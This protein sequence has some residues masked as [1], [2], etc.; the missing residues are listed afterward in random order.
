MP[1]VYQ[2]SMIVT[3][4]D[5]APLRET[6]TGDRKQAVAWLRA[7]AEELDTHDTAVITTPEPPEQAA[8]RQRADDEHSRPAS[9]QQSDITGPPEPRGMDCAVAKRTGFPCT[10]HRWHALNEHLIPFGRSTSESSA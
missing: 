10:D 2:L 5:V 8:C 3:S 6:V 7:L 9:I 1:A 4:D